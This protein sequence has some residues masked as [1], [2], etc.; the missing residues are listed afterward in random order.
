VAGFG[1][2]GS[3]TGRLLKANGVETN[4]LDFDSDRVDLLRRMGLKVYYGDA[5][6]HDLLAAAGAEHARAIV[7]ALDTPE[8]TLQ[9]ART[10]QRHFPHLVV[11]ARA[12]SF[13]DAHALLEAGVHH[14]YRESVDTSARLGVDVLRLMGVHG[15]EAHRAAARFLRHE[16]RT[17][18]ELTLHRSDENR[19]IDAARRAIQDLE[20]VLEADRAAPD[21]AVDSG[22]DPESLRSEVRE[23]AG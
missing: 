9:V 22:W 8:R 12:F 10:V 13:E 6:R 23:R 20:R 3:T 15:H 21:S 11:L 4:V 2:F 5:T 7:L 17:L 16:E 14:V 18:R 19:Y 1:A